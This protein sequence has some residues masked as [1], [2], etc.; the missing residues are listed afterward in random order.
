VLASALWKGEAMPVAWTK[1]HGKG[2]VFYLALGHDARAC[3]NLIFRKLLL[4]G[5][6]WTAI[7]E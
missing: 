5:L 4:Q 6:L 7:E 1:H 3:G 2:R